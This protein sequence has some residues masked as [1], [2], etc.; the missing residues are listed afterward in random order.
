MTAKTH[1]DAHEGAKVMVHFDLYGVSRVEG[2]WTLGSKS[3][4]MARGMEHRIAA[5]LSND[6]IIY[7]VVG[8]EMEATLRRLQKASSHEG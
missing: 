2:Q 6:D 4:P 5:A 3:R 8:D 7:H 1:T